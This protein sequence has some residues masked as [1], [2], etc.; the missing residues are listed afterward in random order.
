MVAL[1]E[2]KNQSIIAALVAALCMFVGLWLTASP[3]SAEYMRQHVQ[4]YVES[5]V[6]SQLVRI[7]YQLRQANKKLSKVAE[8]VARLEGRLNVTQNDQDWGP[9]LPDQAG[10]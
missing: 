1:A 8:S 6:G 4:Q 3:V 9:H 7:E 5:T 10:P 2:M